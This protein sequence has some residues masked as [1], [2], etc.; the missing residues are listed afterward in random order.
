MRTIDP[1]PAPTPDAAAAPDNRRRNRLLGTAAIVAG[2]AGIALYLA[3]SFTMHGNV[4]A[5]CY[6]SNPRAGS[7]VTITDQDGTVIGHSRLDAAAPGT[8]GGLCAWSFEVPDV[9]SWRAV[10]RVQISTYNPVSFDHSEAA[11]PMLVIS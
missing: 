8:Y 3:S 1:G 9:P 4:T 11:A 5:S 10:Y 2:V 7:E 6:L